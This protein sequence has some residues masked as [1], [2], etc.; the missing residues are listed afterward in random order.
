MPPDHESDRAVLAH[1]ARE[2]G[3]EEIVVATDDRRGLPVHQ[4][5]E[6]KLSGIRVT[7]YVAFCER[8]TGS[9]DLE[10]LQPSWFILSD[11]FR[12]GPVAQFVKRSFDLTIGLMFLLLVLPLM[13]VTAVAIK[14]ES[15]GPVFYRQSRIGLRAREFLLLK[16][17]SMRVDAEGNGSPEW[18]KRNDPRTTRV[19]AF[20]RKVRIDELPQLLNV[21]RGEMSLA[22][23]RGPL[24]SGPALL[25]GTSRHPARHHWLGTG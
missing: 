23:F 24:G 14:L 6:C 7:D 15:V 1:K 17:R 9:V 3:V 16:F 11:G 5:L 19:G 10:A 8:E 25:Q 12:T 22:L 21:L 4:L 2:L 20:I 18:A 13:L